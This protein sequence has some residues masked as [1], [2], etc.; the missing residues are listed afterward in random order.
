VQEPDVLLEKELPESAQE[1]LPGGKSGSDLVDGLD[2]P[3]GGYDK[4]LGDFMDEDPFGMEGIEED[5]F[6]GPGADPFSGPDS[7]AGLDID[8]NEK[9]NWVGKNIPDASI[10]GEREMPTGPGG[11]PLLNPDKGPMGQSQAMSDPDK[12]VEVVSYKENMKK[13]RKAELRLM[14]AANKF[15]EAQ[16][17]ALDDPKMEKAWDEWKD[18]V[19]SYNSMVDSKFHL[20]PMFAPEYQSEVGGGHDSSSVTPTKDDVDEDSLK[21]KLVKTEIGDGSEE[22]GLGGG[23]AQS[24]QRELIQPVGGGE[25]PKKK[26]GSA[27]QAGAEQVTDYDEQQNEGTQAN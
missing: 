6:S 4:D 9:E 7:G 16:D 5:P 24:D 25:D 13:M 10:P 17:G 2:D 12:D 27:M 23:I 22:G 1:G 15:E 19:Y 3:T 14:D 8:G 20:D 21:G 11:A 18:A 26:H